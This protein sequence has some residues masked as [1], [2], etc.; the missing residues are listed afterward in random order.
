MP[1]ASP[2]TLSV[3]GSDTLGLVDTWHSYTPASRRVTL[4]TSRDHSSLSG[5]WYTWRKG[6]GFA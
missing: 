6:E 3:R 1:L 5:G 2:T 4:V